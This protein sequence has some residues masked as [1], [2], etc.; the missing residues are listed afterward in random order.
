MEWINNVDWKLVLG[1]WV[2]VEQV[3]GGC[4]AFKANTSLQVV[5]NI[6]D[7]VINKMAKKDGAQ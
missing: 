3:L 4:Q 7:T 5:C 2:L 6:V 1:A